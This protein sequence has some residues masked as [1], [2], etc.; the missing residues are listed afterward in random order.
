MLLAVGLTACGQDSSPVS[1]EAAGTYRAK[2]VTAKFP[3]K[4]RLG[5]TALMRIGVRNSGNETIPALVINVS[6]G[7]EA[8]ETSSLPFGIRDA[9]PGLAQPDRPVWVLSEHFPKLAGS[10]ARGG[11][12]TANNKVYDFGPL[13]PG[14]TTEAVWELT[15]SRTGKYSVFYEVSAGI[16][17]KA[18]AENAAGVQ[19]GGSFSVRITETPPDTIVTDDGEVVEVEEGPESR[20]R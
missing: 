7:G 1:G 9:Q 16:G 14:K 15:A 4:Q 13:R 10:T 20:A 6:V 8:G 12:E 18:K 11:A 2:V 17:G 3:A 19:P 5:E